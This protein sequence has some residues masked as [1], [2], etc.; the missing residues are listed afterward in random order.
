M[1]IRNVSDKGNKEIS[2]L[3]DKMDALNMEWK[4]WEKKGIKRSG[5]D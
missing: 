4:D 3:Y 5:K 1:R 2:K